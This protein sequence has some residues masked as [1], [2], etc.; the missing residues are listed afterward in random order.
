MPISGY[1]WPIV[2]ER[3]ADAEAADAKNINEI[4]NI[5]TAATHHNTE[6]VSE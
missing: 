2:F 4:L 5:S 1:S 6:W 3:P